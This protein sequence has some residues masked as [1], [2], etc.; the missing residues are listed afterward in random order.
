MSSQLQSLNPATGELLGTVPEASA[1]D[2]Q[3]AVSR[4]HSAGGAWSKLSINERLAA[5]KA[6][7]DAVFSNRHTLGRLITMETGKPLVEAWS[8]EIFGALETASWLQKWAVPILA[9]QTVE[10][11]SIFFPFRKAYNQHEPA[12]TVAVISPWN[13][14]FSIPLSTVLC[15][16]AA[17][18]AVVLKPSPKTPLVG[19]AIKSMLDEAGLPDDLVQ[20]VHGD[21]EPAAALVN[22]PVDRVVFTGSVAGGKA[23]MGMC[24]QNVRQVTLELGG[25]HPAIVLADVDV[26]KSARGIVWAA[27]TNAGQACVSI[28]RLYIPRDLASRLLPLIAKYTSQLRLGNGLAPDTDI[29]PVIDAGQLARI[30][31]IMERTLAAGAR[32]L[33]GGKLRPDLGSNYMEPAVLIDCLQGMPAV[34]E[35][36]FGPLLPVVLVDSIDEAVRHANSSHLALGASVW[37]GDR[38]AGEEV[39]KQIQAGMVWVNDSHF[40][41]SCPD[42]PW[43][44]LKA[45]G[46]GRTH[47]KQALAEFTN[48]KCITVARQGDRDW[49]F[50]YSQSRLDYVRNGV[51]LLHAP[52]IKGQA[53]ALWQLMKA[54]VGLR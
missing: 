18:N 29:G 52:G 32:L 11:N 44:G 19:Q 6:V 22:A 10:V 38:H 34:E 3:A 39:A 17:G 47:G 36:I 35:E 9:P 54:Q 20:V 26:D 27:F 50:P 12:G 46:F 42:T 1:A 21:R 43:G 33:C 25:K 41:H 48:T 49:Y 53:G 28:E 37:A 30:R 15:A 40:T 24:A 16:L 4:A 45:S 2:V 13:Y 51:E 23:I 31:S 7:H 5:I 8:G 14:P